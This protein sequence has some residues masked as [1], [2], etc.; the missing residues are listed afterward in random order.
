M[1]VWDLLG[2]SLRQPLCNLLGGYYRRRVPV[3]I[4]LAGRKPAA[5][6][7]ISRE[8]AEQG[9][10]TQTIAA[11]GRPEDDLKTVAA[12]RE[13][14]GDRIE[15]RFDGM[16]RYDMETARDLA[17]GME[18]DGLAVLYS[19]RLDTLELA[20]RGV[21]GTSNERSAGRMAGNPQSGR[22]ADRRCAATQR[23]IW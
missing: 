4:R 13:M 9:F 3:S 6:A 16:G 10:H 1:A 23:R 14:V 12:I 7:Q 22:R 15:L 17:A 21:A 2:R 5:T 8:L 19:I 18:T 11:S 20:S